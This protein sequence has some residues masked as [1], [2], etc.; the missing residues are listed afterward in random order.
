MSD[1]PAVEPRPGR[2]AAALALLLASV[3]G[4]VLALIF[5]ILPDPA[6]RDIAPLAKPETALTDR[7]L[8]VVVDGLR[9]DV[10][11]DASKMPNFARAMREHAHAEVWAGQVTG[12]LRL[13]QG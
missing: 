10:A 11:T 8:F 13:C 5:V 3:L 6:P 2:V 1:D 4:I 9:Y 7:V 12:G